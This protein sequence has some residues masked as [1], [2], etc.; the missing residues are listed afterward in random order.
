VGTAT[1]PTT[2]IPAA[3]SPTPKA[4]PSGP[5]ATGGGGLGPLSDLSWATALAAGAVLA[6]LLAA[7]G[8]F[9][10]VRRRAG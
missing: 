2:A 7:A 1:P 10:T 6:W 8:V 4:T 5:P 9:Y 3:G